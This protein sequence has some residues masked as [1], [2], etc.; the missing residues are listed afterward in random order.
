[1][2]PLPAPYRVS[3]IRSL[4]SLYNQAASTIDKSKC[5]SKPCFKVRKIKHEWRVCSPVP[6]SEKLTRLYREDASQRTAA[7]KRVN[8][9]QGMVLFE[10]Q[11][12]QVPATPRT[13]YSAQSPL[14]NC[15]ILFSAL[16]AVDI[17]STSPRC[18]A[19]SCLSELAQT[20]LLSTLPCHLAF[21]SM[22]C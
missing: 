8:L 3:L 22:G 11:S 2:I 18:L 14:A 12:G 17:R 6:E 15:G 9:T 13:P 1:M 20:L 10:K 5:R 16:A 19:I 4:S 7:S 21:G